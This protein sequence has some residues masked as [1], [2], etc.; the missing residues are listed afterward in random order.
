V[1]TIG[2]CGNVER[3][4]DNP[5]FDAYTPSKCC[6]IKSNIKRFLLPKSSTSAWGG[7]NVAERTVVAEVS[8]SEPASTS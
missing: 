3:E 7:T 4:G 6:E 2:L 1:H 5:S 8:D